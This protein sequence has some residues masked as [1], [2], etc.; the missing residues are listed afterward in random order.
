MSETPQ[1]NRQF[2][3]TFQ[4]TVDSQ[5][6]LA[7]PKLWRLDTDTEDT[8]FYLTLGAGPSLEFYVYEEF[9]KRQAAASQRMRDASSHILGTG[10]AMYATIVQPDKQGRFVVPVPLL[11]IAKIKTNVYCLGCWTYGR[12]AAKEIW[13]AIAPSTNDIISY[14]YSLNPPPDATPAPTPTP[15]QVPPRPVI[16]NDALLTESKVI[17]TEI[18]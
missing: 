18:K 7:I 8:Q 15:A 9:L 13:D 5:H 1:Q 4:S 2:L 16:E 3:M 10:A 14:N 12:I 6:R 11:E 17:V